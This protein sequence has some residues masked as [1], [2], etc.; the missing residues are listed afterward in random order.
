M[1]QV[2]WKSGLSGWQCRLQKNYAS[3]AEFEHSSEIYG[4]H[5]R[6]GFA[7]ALSA[8]E[9]NPLVQGSVHP[10]DFCRVEPVR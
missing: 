5:S 2:I 8:W 1:K 6:L 10:A 9:Q 4:L 7:D 3:F